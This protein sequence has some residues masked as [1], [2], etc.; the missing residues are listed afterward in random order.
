M[1]IPG[2]LSSLFNRLGSR[3]SVP[4]VAILL[5]LVLSAGCGQPEQD[6]PPPPLQ[7]PEYD[8]LSREEIEERASPMT[9]EEAERLGI[10]DTTIHIEPPVNPDSL[11][12]Q[13][14]PNE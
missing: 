10:V 1:R 2:G 7:D 6:A 3:P 8:G 12:L 11:L 14:A 5:S 13:E 4:V 9:P